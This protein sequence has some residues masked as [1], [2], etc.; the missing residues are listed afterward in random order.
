MLRF[1]MGLKLGSIWLLFPN[2]LPSR[3][4]KIGRRYQNA[5]FGVT[6]VSYWLLGDK[7]SQSI[8]RIADENMR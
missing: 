4:C 7:A 6:L 1:G 5:A 3:T 2:A 8:E